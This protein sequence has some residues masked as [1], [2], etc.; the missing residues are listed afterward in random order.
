[1]TSLK[2]S[3]LISAGI[4]LTLILYAGRYDAAPR[5]KTF[6]DRK[7]RVIGTLN[8]A[9]DG[10]Q[11]WAPLETIP[12][13]VVQQTLSK[14][15]R[16]FRWHR[17]VNPVALI[18]AA[19]DNL[20]HGRILRG[21][22]TITQQLARNLIQEKEGKSWRRSL[23]TKLRE[24]TLALALEM[25][26]SKSWILER[27]LNSI[28]Y[29]HRCYG[30]AAA[31]GYY[32]GKELDA[33]T[34]AEIDVLTS[35]PKAPSKSPLTQ[36]LS[37]I[38][39]GGIARH[40][41]EWAASKVDAGPV[42][43]TTLDA[44]LQEKLEALVGKVFESRLEEDPKLTAAIVVIDVR[45]GTL[46]AMVGSRDYFDEAIDGQVNGA[47]ALRQPGSTLK[48]FTY[49]AAFQKGYRA[50]S[51]LM[52]EPVSYRIRGDADAEGY[53]PQNFDR[54]YHGEVTIREA[55][56]NS[57]NIPAVAVLNDI[58]LSYYHETLRR[59]GFTTLKAPPPH[60]G[61]AV[62]LG[63]GEVTLLE[64]TNAY[65]ALARKGSFRPVRFFQAQGMKE[66]QTIGAQAA[67]TA[68]EV[69][70][71]LANPEFRLKAFGYNEDL[72][73]E[74]HPVAVKTGTS[75]NHRDNWTAGYT[76]SYAVGVWVGHADGTPLE[77]TT[78]ATGAG[79]LW[80]AAMETL[81]RGQVAEEFP[82]VDRVEQE[83]N[84]TG[85]HEERA[86]PRAAESRSWKILSPVAG[87]TYRPHG[88]MNEKTQGIM[89]EAEA[90]EPVA[91]VWFLDESKIAETHERKA[92]VL[93]EADPGKHRLRVEGPGGPDTVTFRVIEPVSMAE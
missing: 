40:F 81:L 23:G 9:Y 53:A 3:V 54:K 11:I 92:R 15:D 25:K 30:I 5:A 70:S 86:R 84:F 4:V 60:Y 28:Y 29:G 67:Q 63:S 62:T 46:L 51:L 79:P 20:R 83:K 36:T 2:V 76:P 88:W 59:F 68:L 65:A 57:Y 80:H 90:E 37:P 35:L 6:L 73:I 78:G 42:V 27:Y 41:M 64:L 8:P 72:V 66:S 31:S 91:L 24:T 71:I 61:L 69:T 56:G 55:L 50:G 49:Y 43:K 47:A 74:G 10:L 17:G 82:G 44:A 45:S 33:L 1:M 22:S 16:W 87:S 14:E 38:G 93:I 21:G 85:I 52:D 26:H 19:T 18:K 7:D 75:Y 39:R 12:P 32:F 48:P 34:E 13:P 89:A 58:G 77:G